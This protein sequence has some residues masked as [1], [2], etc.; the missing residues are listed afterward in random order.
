MAETKIKATLREKIGKSPTKKYR[1]EGWIPAEFYSPH[2]ENLH[3]LL[4]KSDFETTLT[5]GHGLLSL[6][7]EG[8]D[9]EIQC[10][11]KELQLDPVRGNVLHADFQGV[12]LGEKLT[13]KVPIALK[14]TAAG[15]K[16]GGILE[17]MIREIEIE[18]FPRDI[19]ENLEIDV[20]NFEIGDSVRVKDLNFEKVRILDDPEETILLVEHSKVAKEIEE[21]EE[22]EVEVEEEEAAE[23][24]VIGRKKEE[25]E[26]KEEEEKKE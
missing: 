6:E 23:P 12:T 1:A 26:E 24:E 14:G 9:K 19:P 20:T 3:L 10:V 2:D 8:H 16:T 11:I 25:E 21:L 13:L 18:C 4:N 7:V 15:V 17:F 5:H 22:A